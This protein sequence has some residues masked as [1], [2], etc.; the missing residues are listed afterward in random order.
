MADNS[1][2]GALSS[3][4]TRNDSV[5]TDHH[6]ESTIQHTTP[7]QPENEFRHMALIV[8]WQEF[9]LLQVLPSL[10][11]SGLLCSRIHH[12]RLDAPELPSFEALSYVWGKERPYKTILV[13]DA[14]FSVRLNLWNF[15]DVSRRQQ[16]NT[17]LFVDAICI[18]QT[19]LQERARQVQLMGEI[20]TSAKQVLIWLG[21]EDKDIASLMILARN[22]KLAAGAKAIAT[23]RKNEGTMVWSSVRYTIG[24]NSGSIDFQQVKTIESGA[25]AI[26]SHAYWRRIW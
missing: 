4:C 6:P 21:S 17:W 10:S 9:R 16:A 2:S 12:F 13:N 1:N 20:Y 3:E 5:L 7:R 15:L 18:D 26:V 19:N 22:G 23:F 24:S 14:L 25:V 11:E 8:G